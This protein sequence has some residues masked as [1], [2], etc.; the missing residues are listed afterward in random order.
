MP[1]DDNPWEPPLAG[2]ETEHLVGA[3]ERLRMT[4]RW[5]AD[6]VDA[7]GLRT[8]IGASA[9]TLGGLLKH[10]AANEDYAF[11]TKLTGEPIGAPWEAAGWDG[12]NDWEFSSAAGDDPAVL[13]ALWDGAVERSRARLGVALESGGLDQ[14]VHMTAADGRHASLRRLLCDLIEEYGRHTG[15]ADL[16][17]EAVDG[18]TGEDPPV[19]WRPGA[20]PRPD[21][22]QRARQVFDG[23]DLRGARFDRTDLTDAHMRAVDLTGA[24]FRGCALNRVVMRGVELGGVSIDGEIENLTIN[25]VDVGPLIDAELNAGIRTGPACAHKVRRAFA[26]PGTSSSGSGPGPSAGLA[27]W[28]PSCC[29]SRSTASGR[30]SRRCATWC[31]RPTPGSGGP[32]SATPRRG[33]RWTCRGTRCPTPPAYPGTAS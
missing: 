30:S 26:M 15:H 5:K 28:L 24:R 4:F 2:T 31:S 23:A 29:T 21:D 25:G 16:L 6:G 22:E 7:A 14:A 13:C 11:T 18:V 27:G 9:L 19:G 33:I 12:S 10:L 17:R 1:N 20:T 8:R 3:L 32:C